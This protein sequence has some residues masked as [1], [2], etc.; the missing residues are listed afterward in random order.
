M[1]GGYD[2]E[3][4]WVLLRKQAFCMRRLYQGG[5]LWLSQENVFVG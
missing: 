2:E 1:G 4:V 3:G 5:N